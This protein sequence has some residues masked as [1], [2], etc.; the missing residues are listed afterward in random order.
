MID[1]DPGIGVPQEKTL[2]I[3][4][5]INKVGVE[6]DRDPELL[7]EREMQGQG[8]DSVPELV[9]IETG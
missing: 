1:P 2:K 5:E 6:K 8:Q 3:D 4:T 7:L 9:L